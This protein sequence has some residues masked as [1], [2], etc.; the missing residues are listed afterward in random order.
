MTNA[1]F[2][3]NLAL[4]ARLGYAVDRTKPFGGGTAVYLSKQI[5]ARPVD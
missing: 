5:G 2:A 1:A 4:Y 3:A